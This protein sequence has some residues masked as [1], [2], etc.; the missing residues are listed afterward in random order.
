MR[1]IKIICDGLSGAQVERACFNLLCFLTWPEASVSPANAPQTLSLS[2][3][4]FV[5]QEYI[6]GFLNRILCGTAS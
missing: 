6:W 4:I 2:L 1:V 3:Q 5:L